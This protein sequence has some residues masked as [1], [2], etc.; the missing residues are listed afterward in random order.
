MRLNGLSVFADG[1][2][3]DDYENA[4]RSVRQIICCALGPKGNNIEQAAMLWIKR[5]GIVDKSEVFLQDTPELC[6]ELARSITGEGVVPVF[7]TCAVY[8]KENEFFFGNPDVFPFFFQQEMNLDEMQLA[9]RK[10]L[11]NLVNGI[12]RSWKIAS[13]PSPAPLV[14]P[15]GLEVELCNS[16]AAAAQ[17]CAQGRTELCITTESARRLNGLVQL[18]SFGS[19]NMIFFGG[20]TEHGKNQLE[21]VMT[22]VQ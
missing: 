12:P 5:L 9:T 17:A 6:L 16:N 10:E 14:R 13:H 21:R 2:K 19:P 20:I 3:N 15:L 7:W 1:R 18:H 4:L 22:N 11:A 8:S